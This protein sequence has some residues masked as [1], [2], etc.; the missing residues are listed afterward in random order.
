[1]SCEESVVSKSAAPDGDNHRKSNDMP[2]STLH[3]VSYG[4]TLQFIIC[5]RE[6]PDTVIRNVAIIPILVIKGAVCHTF[7]VIALP[8]THIHVIS[9]M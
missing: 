7:S 6:L 1:M 4:A 2:G 8:R 9:S 5:Q 3:T